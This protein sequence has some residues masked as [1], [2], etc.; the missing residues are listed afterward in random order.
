MANRRKQRAD[1]SDA[2]TVATTPGQM[3]QLGYVQV[4]DLTSSVLLTPPVGAN[5]AV[6][7]AEGAPVRWRDDN[8]APTA[9]IGMRLPVNSELRLDSRLDTVRVIQEAAGAKLNISYYG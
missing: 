7:Q 2:I 1:G 9:A 4:A 3:F 8:V 6:I 5:Y